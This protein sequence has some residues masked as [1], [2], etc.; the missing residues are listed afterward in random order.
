MKLHKHF[1]LLY[2]TTMIYILLPKMTGN[3]LNKLKISSSPQNPLPYMSYSFNHYLTEIKDKI[4]ELGD[5][6]NTFKKYTNPYEYIHTN[7]YRT[8]VC[9]YKP[10]S[11]AYF[12]MVEIINM[13]N[14]QILQTHAPIQMFALAEGPGGFIEAVLNYRNNEDDRYFG[15]TIEDPCDNEVPGWKK[16]AAFLKNHSNIFIEKG[17]DGT[18][19]ILNID[20]FRD[21]TS[22]Y[23]NQMDFVTGDGGFDFSTD[24]NNQEVNI[25][26]LLF[27][28]I[29]YAVC[30]QKIGG[31]FVLKCFDCFHKATAELIFLLSTMYEKVHIVKP[32]T[33]RYANSERYLVC[34]NFLC[35]DPNIVNVFDELMVSLC[36]SPLTHFVKSFFNNMRVPMLFYNKLEESNSIICQIQLDNIYNTIALIKNNYKTDKINYYMKSHLHKCV[37]WCLKNK[38]EYHLHNYVGGENIEKNI[39]KPGAKGGGGGSNE[40]KIHS[41]S[42][43]E[44]EAE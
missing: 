19:N 12:K 35:T 33:S 28:Q 6:W 16:T 11:R 24:F 31:C 26:N 13:F 2:F 39:F 29:A 40:T 42:L 5:D 22:K 34:T 8:S 10:I 41:F 7:S 17:A 23:Q 36:N 43:S 30:I 4:E 21:V 9:K 38:M 44:Y 32:N 14:F 27:A 3:Y 37:Q 25:V 15:I 18:G 20:N 1:V